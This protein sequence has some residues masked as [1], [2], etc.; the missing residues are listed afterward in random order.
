M[1][2][3][4]FLLHQ[5]FAGTAFSDWADPTR[6]RTIGTRPSGCQSGCARMLKKSASGVLAS[7]RGSTLSKSFSEAGNTGGAFPFAKTHWKGERPTRSAVRTSSPLRLLRPWWTD[8][9]SILE[10][11]S[12]VIPHVRLADFAETKNRFPQPGKDRVLV[13]RTLDGDYSFLTYNKG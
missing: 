2:F 9:L 1:S 6:G 5:S 13:D 8:F 11:D 10:R 3:W 7:L 4:Q 12:F